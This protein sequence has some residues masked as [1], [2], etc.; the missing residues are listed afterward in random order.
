MAN[1]V[2][3]AVKANLD[4]VLVEERTNTVR[5]IAWI[6]ALGATVATV[7]MLTRLGDPMT[8]PSLYGSVTFLGISLGLL[9]ALSVRPSLAGLVAYATPCIDAPLLAL[10]QA[11]Q[12]RLLAPYQWMGIPN[13]VA[14]MMA[15]IAASA[16]T[17]SRPAVVLC[18]VV[19]V[20]SNQLTFERAG[21]PLTPRL[22]AAIPPV[23]IAA[24]GI[25]LMDRLRSITQAARRRDLLGKYVLGNRLGA[26]GM[27]E[28][29]EATYSPEG[30]FERRVA[31]KRILPSIAENPEAV[32]LFRREAEVGARLAH[33][34]I[35]QV[36][37]FGA[38]QDSYFIAMEYVDGTTLSR[39]LNHLRAQQRA[40]PVPV[41]V[42]VAVQLAEALAYVHERASPTGSLMGLVHRD[43]NPPNVMVSRLGEVKL[44]DFGIARAAD[45][46]G[47][48]R[49][50]MLRGKIGY[51]APEQLRS[52][53]YD[54]RA[55]LFSLG[56]TLYEAL[57]GRKLFAGESDLSVIKAC[58]E[59][60]VPPLAEL[61]PD[62]PLVLEDII[63]GLLERELLRRTPSAEVLRQQLAKLPP[64]LL[65][66]RE[67]QRV[68]AGLVAEVRAVTAT[69]A[70]S[71]ESASG[72]TNPTLPVEDATRTAARPL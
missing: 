60:P 9:V 24:I 7:V 51:S 38:D 17:L 15:L 46:P 35:V 64:E 57:S 2:N 50:G 12:Q 23:M 37:D 5:R 67:A 52:E 47:L 8:R 71:P 36:L 32:A 6:R 59:Q 19:A 28:V 4:R 16:L 53:P 14:F 1:D 55:D 49:T 11:N 41:L 48:T 39:L 45:Q 31:V 72:P 69:P 10:I 22:L 3:A 34:N 54:A 56:V 62:V 61:R 70:Q 25:T 13:N 26:G 43:L 29:F 18:A 63:R 66:G 42:H 21:L 27:A 20:V 40:L 30:G 58:L 44:G 68:L 33:P 65:D